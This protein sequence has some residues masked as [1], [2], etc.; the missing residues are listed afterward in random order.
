MGALNSELVLGLVNG[1]L[2]WWTPAELEKDRERNV[3]QNDESPTN[4]AEI[5]GKAKCRRYKNQQLTARP[6]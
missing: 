4:Q 5:A 6:P 3:K 1:V 2:N